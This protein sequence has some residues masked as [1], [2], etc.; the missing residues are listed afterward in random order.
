MQ[1]ALAQP[2]K[3]S[4]AAQL[5]DRCE[6]GI[7]RCTIQT[8]R[9]RDGVRK[10]LALGRRDVILECAA[11][12]E[13]SPGGTALMEAAELFEAAGEADRAC[14]IYI[15][16][17]AFA[18]AEPL[19]RG[20]RNPKLLLSVRSWLLAAETRNPCCRWR[21]TPQAP[22]V[23]A[24]LAAGRSLPSALGSGTFLALAPLVDALPLLSLA[25]LRLRGVERPSSFCRCAAPL[26][27]IF[28]PRHSRAPSR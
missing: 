21:G 17:K 10:V 7:A 16:A 25:E 23:G 22:A 1:E 11:M 14:A 13:S 18:R 28:R 12:L 19:M 3:A 15:Q 26:V 20:V 6:A 8:G 27:A 4:T 9:V 24:L 5:R 2:Q